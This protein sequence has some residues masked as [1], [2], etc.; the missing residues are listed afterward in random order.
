M[1]RQLGQ[2]ACAE[3]RRNGHWTLR[4]VNR[5]LVLRAVFQYGYL[6]R[7]YDRVTVTLTERR[8]GFRPMGG[9]E[10]QARQAIDRLLGLAVKFPSSRQLKSRESGL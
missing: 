1:P 5:F 10:Q 9:T 4:H 8:E 7:P 3:A 2:F 6:P